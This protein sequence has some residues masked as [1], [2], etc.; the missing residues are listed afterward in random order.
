MKIYTRAGDDGTTGLLYGGRVPKTSAPIEANGDVDEAQ[1]ALGVAR[2]AARTE[3]G[4]GTPFDEVLIGLERDLYVLMAEVATAP[5]NRSKLAPGQ[6]VVTA[7][8]VTALEGHIDR[9]TTE[10]PPLRDFTIPGHDP[11]SA[12]LDVARTVV[13]RA[14]RRIAALADAG[15]LADAT[16]IHLVNRASDLVYAMARFADV[17]DPALFEGRDRG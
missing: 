14:E 2:A 4:S 8:M 11:V 13:R 3:D 5:E 15:E 7:E 9:L 6:S 1:A 12:A 16:V 17:G 10:F